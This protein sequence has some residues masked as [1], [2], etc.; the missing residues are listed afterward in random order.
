[1]GH[2]VG[3]TTWLFSIALLL[4]CLKILRCF[5]W[6]A[7]ENVKVFLYAAVAALQYPDVD[8]P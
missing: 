3:E 6:Q 2:Q 7:I 4:I 5:Q 8:A 1:M